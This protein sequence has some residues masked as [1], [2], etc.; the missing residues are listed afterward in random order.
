MLSIIEL[1]RQHIKQI[2]ALEIQYQRK[3]NSV[4]LLAVSKQQ[5]LD[6]IQALC[7]AGQHDFGE[8]YLA[9]ALSKLS[10][11]DEKTITWHFIGQLQSRK[12][13]QISNHFN[14]IHSVSR[15]KE[16]TLLNEYRAHRPPLNVCI[17]V[18]IQRTE[19]KSGIDPDQLVDLAH[20]IQSLPNLHLRG[21][22]TLPEPETDFG[23]Q[24]Q[25]FKALRNC[26]EELNQHGMNCDTLSMGTSQDYEAAIKEGATII[27]LGQSLFGPRHQD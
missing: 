12:I 27:R 3:P 20:H 25:P 1:W 8:N 16:A 6:S 4:L 19:H 14:W 26:L 15:L 23:A 18:N 10:A 21:L 5:S 7:S 11:L 13:A 17:Q 2:R 9:E 22:M 24:C